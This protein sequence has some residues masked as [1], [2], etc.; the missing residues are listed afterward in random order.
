VS[1]ARGHVAA[2]ALV[3]AD[4]VV[5]GFSVALSRDRTV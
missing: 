1:P 3:R 2:I 4:D 5:S